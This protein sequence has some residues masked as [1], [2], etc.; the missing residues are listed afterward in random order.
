MPNIP[1]VLA[2]PLAVGALALA[3]TSGAAAETATPGRY[4]MTPADGG[5][6]RL[7]TETG[8]MALCAKKDSQWACEPMPDSQAAQRRDIERL[9]AENKALKDEV[10]RMEEMLGLG[11]PKPGDGGAK[12]A[13]RPKGG[14]GLPSEEDVDKAFDYVTRMLKKFQEKMRELEGGGG[15]GKGGTP[16]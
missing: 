12:K 14:P 11:D 8:A 5:F 2:V 4:T 15:P 6:V 3:S 1:S 13:E 9:E 7:D 16:L 10:R